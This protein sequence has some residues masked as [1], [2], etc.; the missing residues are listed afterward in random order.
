MGCSSCGSGGCST[1]G[2]GTGCGNNDIKG[3][4]GCNKLNVYDWL[5]GMKLPPGHKPF[6]IVEVRFKGSR[7]EFFRNNNN[8]ELYMGDPVIVD[9]DNGFDIGHV[10]LK[11]ELVKLQLKKYNIADTDNRLKE[12]Q[13]LP[14]ENEL[15]RYKEIKAEEAGMLQRART[16]ALQMGLQMKLSDIELQGDRKKVIF[17]YTAEDRVDFRELIKKYADEFR[18]RIEMR[19]IGYR[20]EASRLG[21]IGSCGRELCCST[22]LTDFK[23][24]TTS[25]ARYQNL[26]MNPLKLQG[27]CGKLKCCL[28]YELDTY[29]EAWDNF[30]PNIEK[31]RLQ[32]KQGVAFLQK[33]DILK[34]MMW[35]AYVREGVGSEWVA[36]GVQEVKKVIELN[37]AGQSPETLG[38]KD[39]SN[40][41]DVIKTL[42][43]DMEGSLTRLDSKGKRGGG[44]SGASR[45]KN[46]NSNNRNNNRGGGGNKPN[47]NSGNNTPPPPAAN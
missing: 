18:T 9:A 35:F 46:R 26:S 33:T 6:N 44:G 10:S 34:Q 7:K 41:P 30:P 22:W 17:F 4:S 42:T 1:G 36:L 14:R 27:Q 2:C 39:K 12:I 13:R 23:M 47:N 45:N 28:N 43:E 20:Q 5:G 24:V 29:L 32:T 21:G 37:K 25:A 31:L 8:I 15:V 40:E 3:T 11:G 38:E 19:Q 16:V